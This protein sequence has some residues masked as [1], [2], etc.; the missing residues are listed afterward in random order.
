VDVND[1]VLKIARA[2]PM[3]QQRVQFQ[4]GD[5]YALPAFPWKFTGGLAAFWWS[6]VP[7]QRLRNFLAGL[8]PLFS[9]GAVIVFIDNRYVEGSSTPVSR[10][11]A[12]GNTYQTRKLDDGSTHEVL[13][14][15]P[16]GDELRK[17]VE[18]LASGVRVEFLQ[19][20]W[21][22]SYAPMPSSNEPAAV[23]KQRLSRT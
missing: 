18:G 11:D 10:A 6:H 17:S 7:K 16:T 8:N 15:F 1:E 14:N 3:D 19:Y 2:K 5:A 13:K 21:T 23:L 20:Y 9:P 4:K 22:L 12:D